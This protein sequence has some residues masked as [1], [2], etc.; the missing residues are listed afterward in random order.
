MKNFIYN[1]C[2]LQ[3]DFIK[4][5]LN[6]KL[7]S[8]ARKLSDYLKSHKFRS[9]KQPFGV[10]IALQP[11]FFFQGS[12]DFSFKKK[13][14]NCYFGIALLLY[15]FI[16]TRI[17]I[18]MIFSHQQVESIMPPFWRVICFCHS[19]YCRIILIPNMNRI[20]WWHVLPFVYFLLLTT[21]NVR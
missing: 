11:I 1:C 2:Y 3:F 10:L 5:K 17:Y 9:S 14:Q 15:T 20:Y 7:Q 18:S 13:L 21:G 16:Y 19:F 4:N 8:F 12:L 6:M